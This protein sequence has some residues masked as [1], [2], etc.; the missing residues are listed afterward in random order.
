MYQPK[1]KL[2]ALT[3]LAGIATAFF[4]SAAH[5]QT[6]EIREKE[7]SLKGAN[8]VMLSGTLS[9]P[10]SPGKFPA[11]LFISGSGPTDRDGNSSVGVKTD[12]F[13]LLATSL[14]KN[15][16][17]SLRFDKR[18]AG[19]AR[20]LIPRTQNELSEYCSWE[21]F[22]ADAEDAFRF[23]QKQPEIDAKSTGIF[24]HSEGGM[25]ALQMSNNLKLNP[26]AVL[27]IAGT[28]G[29]KIDVILHD[30]LSLI[31]TNQKAP[32]DTIAMILKKNAE[33]CDAIRKTGVIPNDVP[34]GLAALYPAYIG[35]FL[36]SE[37]AFDPIVCASNYEGPVL[38]LQGEKDSQVS[39]IFDAPLLE[40]ALKKR[41]NGRQ[42]LFIAP[43]ASHNL[44]ALKNESDLGFEGAVEPTTLQK[45]I[46]WVKS[47]LKKG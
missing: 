39:A 36:H 7:V 8:R 3:V 38:I 19:N 46:D 22:V 30:Q 6:T 45:I 14:A 24:G 16:V 35:K 31:M 10:A 17:A 2:R 29:R 18:V 4:A 28:P 5:S 47:N 41:V 43:G 1:L 34:P 33:I 12:L 40:K 21:Y 44:K 11:L 15:G 42:E 13:R 20:K 37:L 25:L 27:I 9:L 23:L 26:P 32:P